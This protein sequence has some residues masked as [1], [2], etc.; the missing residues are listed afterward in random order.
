MLAVPGVTAIEESVL[1]ASV[2]VPL[3]APRVAV[4]VVEPAATPVAT[5]VP[6]L[7][8]ATLVDELV[9]VQDVVISAVLVSEYVPVA[10]NACVAVPI[11]VGV[12]G[13][14]AI[15]SSVTTPPSRSVPPPSSGDRITPTG[16]ATLRTL[17][18]IVRSVPASFLTLTSHPSIT[19]TDGRTSCGF[20]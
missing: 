15:E 16:Y 14:T 17:K 11:I 5:P 4:I 12:A 2:A 18:F 9:H 6:E 8:V 10:V 7:I 1:T 20:A 19:I 3:M 13:V